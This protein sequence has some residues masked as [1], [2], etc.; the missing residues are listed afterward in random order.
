MHSTD[1]NPAAACLPHELSATVSLPFVI[2]QVY[3]EAAQR[4]R[5]RIG[6]IV[7]GHC[8]SDNA[9][10]RIVRELEQLPAPA[11]GKPCDNGYGTVDAALL[12]LVEMQGARTAREEACGV[13]LAHY[14]AEG[15]ARAATLTIKAVR[16][17]AS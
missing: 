3:T 1:L 14:L 15:D 8:F 2:T 17:S 12:S 4:E 5:R 13:I 6:S 9:A 10:A 11:L 16:R 7:Y